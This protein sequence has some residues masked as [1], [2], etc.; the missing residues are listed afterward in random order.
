MM[1]EV[2]NVVQKAR[3]LGSEDHR[4]ASIKGSSIWT[5]L[6]GDYAAMGKLLKPRSTAHLEKMLTIL[7]EG[8]YRGFDPLIQDNVP[9][10]LF[11]LYVGDWK[12]QLARWPTPTSQEYIH[13][14]AVVE[15][16]K[17]FLSACFHEHVISKVLLFNFQDRLT[18][19]EHFRAAAVES[20]A[21]R[22]S[23]AKHI[24]VVTLPKDTEFYYQLAPYHQ[25]NKA[26]TFISNFKEQLKDEGC[27]TLLPDALKAR[28]L[29]EFIPQ[30]LDGV[31]RVFFS[32]K[33]VL[34]RESRL[35]FIEIFYLFF[36]LKVIEKVKPDIVGMSCKDGLDVTLTSA[37]PLY[38]LFKLLNQERMS[39]IDKE[40]LEMTLYGHCLINRE[41]LILPERFNRMVNAIKVMESVRDQ[42]GVPA[43]TQL[44]HE[45]FGHLYQSEILKGKVVV[46]SG[47]D[48]F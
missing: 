45:A 21:E 37:V 26:E 25:D 47:K 20:L 11:S 22:E 35:D 34:T 14:V 18:W 28:L 23:Y 46:Q 38:V 17:A 44:I 8:D 5:T 30:A 43:F 13:K 39:E 29:K 32:G 42:L 41:R 31:H 33:N 40:H 9:S 16:F 12:V 24:E 19:R 27:G 7:E 36:M 48:V 15:E 2:N 10:Q 4:K 6:A 3:D 1:V